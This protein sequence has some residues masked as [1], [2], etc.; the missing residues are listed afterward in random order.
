MSA[1]A[2]PDHELAPE[3][4]AELLGEG[5]QVIDLREGYERTAGHIADTR[6][7]ELERLA[8]QADTIDRSAPVIFYCRLGARSGM[9]TQAFRASGYDAYNMSGGISEWARRGLPLEPTDG[10]VAE[11]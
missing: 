3:R 9:A 2:E 5:W 11:H 8:S 6:H 1:F 10:H 7:V 4:V